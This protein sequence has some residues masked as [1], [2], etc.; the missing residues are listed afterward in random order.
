MFCIYQEPRKK[1]DD[2]RGEYMFFYY[3]IILYPYGLKKD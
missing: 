1:T 2:L 3:T